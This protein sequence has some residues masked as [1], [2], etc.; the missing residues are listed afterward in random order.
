MPGAPFCNCATFS[1][2]DIRRIKSFARGNNVRAG[3]RQ[4][5]GSLISGMCVAAAEKASANSEAQN[6]TTAVPATSFASNVLNLAVRLAGRKG[7]CERPFEEI[8][9][10]F[11]R[12][13]D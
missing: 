12:A 2:S 3:S 13:G 11:N 4:M 1:A 7:D 9:I 5:A 8:I 6:E 10:M